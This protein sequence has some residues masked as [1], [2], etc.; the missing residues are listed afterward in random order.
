M[1]TRMAPCAFEGFLK[2]HPGESAYT[3]KINY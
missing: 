3:V 1:I 2:D